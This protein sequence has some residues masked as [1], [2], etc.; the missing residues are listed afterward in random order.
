M[1]ILKTLIAALLISASAFAQN[2]GINSD[3]TAPDASAMLDVKSTTKGFLAPRMTAAQRG[4]ITSPAA[5]LLV[6][7]T[8]ATAGY[9]YY[10]G[11]SWTQ[12]GAASGASQWTTTGSDIYYNAGK[13]GIGT[14]TPLSPLDVRGVA[15]AFNLALNI[16][17][18]GST[19]RQTT[20]GYGGYFNIDNPTGNIYLLN[21]GSSVA[22]GGV[23]T[24]TIKL[25]LTP[26]GNVGIG[27]TAPAYKL[28][29]SSGDATA[30]RLGPNTSFS[31]SLL[32]GG[33]NS[34]DFSEARIQTSTGNLHLDAKSG[35][36]IYIN[37]YHTGNVLIAG[38]GGNVGIGTTTPAVKLD[39]IGEANFSE[40]LTIAKN[41]KWNNAGYGIQLSVVNVG[42][43]D[44]LVSR[45]ASGSSWVDVGSDAAWSG[46]TLA[47]GGGNV[48]IGTTTPD[49][50]L[51]I[52]TSGGVGLKIN[53]GGDIALTAQV[54][55]GNAVLYNDF[56]T[57]QVNASAG[58]GASC[59]GHTWIDVSDARLKRDIQP[60]TH[61]GLG[62][63]MQLKPVTYY[64]KSD[65]ANHPEV[66]F[67][68]QE[69]LKIVP[70]VV[71]G[72]LGDL[73]KG[74]TLGLSYG[75]LVPVLTKA[76]QEQQAEIEA[77]KADLAEIKKIMNELKF[78]K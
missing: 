5:G 21:T 57:L 74:E 31:R 13:V 32:L 51:A 63:V 37:N 69:M 39:V 53:N 29:I 1:K 6:Y 47:A 22:A 15:S 64:F 48:G 25:T 11:S 23:T 17:Y 14:T 56:G 49:V 24:P 40:S 30:I 28:D 26:S 75:N 78:K 33:W 12:L 46:V 66:G 76:I 54:S 73:E 62:T 34:T 52:A 42:P 41:I 60:L 77:L 61:Y 71:H 9:Y 72:T 44:A 10:N 59:D 35:N 70:E 50:P 20:A 58:Y 8:D 55:G 65:P 3:G 68:A 19:W 4:E 27:T 45:N 7:Q 36:D 43:K 2:V 38:G 18:D 16:Y 67:I